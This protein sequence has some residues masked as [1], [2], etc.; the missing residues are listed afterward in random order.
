M[1]ISAV[2]NCCL[3]HDQCYSSCAVPQITCDNF[4]A[5]LGTI[6]ASLHC[7]NNL[8]LHCNAVHWLGHKYICPSMAQ[9]PT[10]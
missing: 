1:N 3:R 9:P 8:A 7:Q 10:D 2:N 4:C 5:C 6:P